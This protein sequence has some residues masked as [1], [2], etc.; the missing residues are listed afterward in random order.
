MECVRPYDTLIQEWGDIMTGYDPKVHHRRSIRLR[1]YDY[2]LPGAYFVTIVTQGR[3]CLFDDPLFCSVAETMWQR[4]PRHFPQVRLDEWVVMPN[5]LHGILVLAPEGEGADPTLDERSTPNGPPSGSLGAI[6]GNFKS[7][8]ARR[9]NR[10]R[11]TPGTRVW[12]RNYHER[13]IR[14]EREWNAIRQYIRDNPAHWH[15]DPDHPDRFV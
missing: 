14:N 2:R 1:G 4:V 3:V 10:I 9:I 11:K 6:V 5:H 8:T 12:Q 7:V 15:D 13:V